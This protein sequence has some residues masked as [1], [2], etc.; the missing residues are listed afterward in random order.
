[1]TVDVVVFTVREPTLRVLLIRRGKPPFHRRWAL[2]G[3]F[4]NMDEPLEDAARRELAEEAGLTDLWLE[5]LY[6][7]GSPR[8]DPR[9]RVIT[10]AYLGLVPPERIADA[11]AGDDADRLKWCPVRKLTAMAFDHH[12]IVH[13]ALKRLRTKLEYT[14]A[15]FEL[16]PRR[17]ALSQLQAVYEAI[18]ARKLDK[19]NFRRKM[20]AL[21]ILDPT[22]ATR[23][24]GAHRPARLYRFSARK[25]E[26]LR[27][28]GILFPF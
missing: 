1:M 6:T 15:G 11:A 19:R 7:F 10:V 25:F 13:C 4:V 20:L 27:D 2:P 16:L 3:G 28:R 18:L 5:Q 23:R 21:N 8:R 26:N 12:Q 17:F 9:G 24:D 14:T 22:P